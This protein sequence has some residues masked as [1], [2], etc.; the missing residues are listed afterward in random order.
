[1]MFEPKTG[2]QRKNQ[3]NKKIKKSVM[4][5][6]TTTTTE[7][8]PKMAGSIAVAVPRKDGIAL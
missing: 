3:K 1:M 7:E 4:K 5:V 2:S 6:R 8:A